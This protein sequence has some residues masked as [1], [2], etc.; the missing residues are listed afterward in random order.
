MAGSI[1]EAISKAQQSALTAGLKM[2]KT[3][4]IT[5]LS[6]VFD[7]E[8]SYFLNG[9]KKALK[10]NSPAYNKWKKNKFGYETKG[11]LYKRFARALGN[12]NNAYQTGSN[13]WKFDMLKSAP[14]DVQEYVGYYI[15]GTDKMEAKAPGM[16]GFSQNA[17][18]K[19]L[20]A[21]AEAFL[22]RFKDEIAPLG[23]R[24]VSVRR[25]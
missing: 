25:K 10:E 7:N 16:G 18:N 4:G 6:A 5:E 17:T 22:R 1:N 20:D 2:G 23:Y 24:V 11:H 9:M 8:E 21:Q 3:F 13:A 19:I 12:K 14:L 15:N